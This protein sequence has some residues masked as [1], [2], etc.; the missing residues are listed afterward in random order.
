M[1]K[2]TRIARVIAT[3]GLAAVAAACQ[4]SISITVESE[5]L[6][7]LV[8]RLPI[9]VGVVYTDGFRNHEYAEDSEERGS[10]RIHSGDSHVATFNRIFQSLFEQ[11][12]VVSGAE[13]AQVDLVIVPKIASMQFSMPDE[14]GLDY[15]EAWISYELQL[16][17]GAGQVLPPWQFSAYGNAE[18]ARLAGAETAL[19]ESLSK[20]L[21]N[22]GA[23]LATEF[24]NH[25]PLKRLLQAP[26]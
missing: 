10:W 6:D 7:A 12:N 21:R 2:V 13:N 4:K 15:F 17:S 22:A 8:N 24:E 19:N 25:P 9:S 20:A 18:R 16:Q 23:T 14:T 1:N 5:V 26:R 3:I 11:F